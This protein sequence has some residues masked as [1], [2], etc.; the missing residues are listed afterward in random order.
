MTITEIIKQAKSQMRTINR[1]RRDE[2]FIRVI[3]KLLHLKLLDAPGMLPYRGTIFLDE[4]LWVGEIEPRVLALLPAILLKRPKAITVVGDLP[5][6]LKKII[7][8]IRHQNAA[9]PFRGILAPEYLKWISFVGRKEKRPTLLKTFRFD[10]D[11]LA[12]L[13]RLRK[14]GNSEIDVIR[15]AMFA[16]EKNAGPIDKP[17]APR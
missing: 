14:F 12:R 9:T 16:L 8:D 5:E 13:Q 1:K 11:D 10:H 6:D 4:V 7:S 2:R 17:N 15:K 3:G